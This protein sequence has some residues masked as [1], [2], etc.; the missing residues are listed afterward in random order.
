M[1]KTMSEKRGRSPARESKRKLVVKDLS[2]SDVVFSSCGHNERPSRQ[3]NKIGVA[4]TVIG[5]EEARDKE[6]AKNKNCPVVCGL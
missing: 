5:I 4:A 2:V 3:M 6:A 1:Q